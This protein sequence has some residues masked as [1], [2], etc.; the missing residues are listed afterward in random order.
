MSVAGMWTYSASSSAP[1]SVGNKVQGYWK[2]RAE[3][4]G[5]GFVEGRLD[6][7]V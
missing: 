1:P 2:Y 3:G 5:R 6:K 7:L 4:G